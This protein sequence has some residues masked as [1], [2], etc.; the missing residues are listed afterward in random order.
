MKS[1]ILKRILGITILALFFP[2]IF[3]IS[4]ID[5]QVCYHGACETVVPIWGGI[6]TGLYLDLALGSFLGAALGVIWLLV[7]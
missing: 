4:S 2:I 3:G 7:S 5:G 6:V 1:K